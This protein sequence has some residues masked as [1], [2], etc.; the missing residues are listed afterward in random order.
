MPSDGA[1]D[2]LVNF[3]MGKMIGKGMFSSVYR[4]RCVVDNVP[5]A[6]KKVKVRVAIDFH[7]D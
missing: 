4:A 2:T 7:Y 1:Y 6:L 3:E 5:V